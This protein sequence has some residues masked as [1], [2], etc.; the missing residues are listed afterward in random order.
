MDFEVVAVIVTVDGAKVVEAVEL[1]QNRRSALRYAE[2]R[3]LLDPLVTVE[4]V[5][6]AAH[7]IA[8]AALSADST[9]A[10]A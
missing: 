9:A 7:P 6:A 2:T 5:E 4:V 1:P 8:S 3:R 10:L